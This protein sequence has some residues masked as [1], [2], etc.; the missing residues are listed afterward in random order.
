MDDDVT[1]TPQK[2]Q[3]IGSLCVCVCIHSKEQAVINEWNGKNDVIEQKRCPQ[4]YM[5]VRQ[6]EMWRRESAGTC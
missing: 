5:T 1:G 2:N 4:N 3:H 6:S